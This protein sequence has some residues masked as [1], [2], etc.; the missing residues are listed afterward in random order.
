M[1]GIPV[2]MVLK[3]DAFY[4]HNLDKEVTKHDLF[5]ITLVV[6][7]TAEQAVKAYQQY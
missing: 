1:S 2:S 5:K 4:E 7:I 3:F 6:E